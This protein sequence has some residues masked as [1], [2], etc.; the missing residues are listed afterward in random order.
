MWKQT[1]RDCD[2]LQLVIP[3]DYRLEAM[4]RAHN[5]IGHLGL[6]WMPDILC[7]RFY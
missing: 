4:H 3:P 5:D 6:K 2:I 7:S 1:Q